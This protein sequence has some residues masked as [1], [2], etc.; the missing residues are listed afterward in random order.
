[1]LRSARAGHGS[2][3]TPMYQAGPPKRE[4]CFSLQGPVGSAVGIVV[5]K[6]FLTVR[7]IFAQSLISGCANTDGYSSYKLT[8]T[9][10]HKKIRTRRP[11]Y[12][13]LMV[14]RLDSNYIHPPL[15]QSTP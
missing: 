14:G 12:R 13:R 5:F 8:D 10:T 15:S 1:M 3:K 7:R 11:M 4:T 6:F 2:L 9:P